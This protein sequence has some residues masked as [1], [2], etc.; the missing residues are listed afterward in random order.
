MTYEA[1]INAFR[2]K[3]LNANGYCDF[4]ATSIEAL[5]QE[6]EIAL[7]DWL[8]DCKEDGISPFCENADYD[9]WFREQVRSSIDDPRPS[10]PH[11]VAKARFSAKRESLLAIAELEAGKGGKFGNIDDLMEDLKADD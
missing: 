8:Q 6:G 11:E 4:I 10:I 2:G 3:F 9:A 1:D 7:N 5:H